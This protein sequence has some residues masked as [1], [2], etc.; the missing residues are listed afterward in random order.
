[1]TKPPTNFS[2]HSPADLQRAEGPPKAWAVPE[3]SDPAQRSHF[4][5]WLAH[6]EAGRIGAHL[7]SNASLHENGN[8]PCPPEVAR[9]REANERL[10]ARLAGRG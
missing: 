10:F 7:C 8:P 4:Q 2:F 6:V 9:R 5:D 3:P 1:M